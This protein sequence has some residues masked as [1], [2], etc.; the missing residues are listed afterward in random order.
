MPLKLSPPLLSVTPIFYIFVVYYINRHHKFPKNTSC[1][2]F[3]CTYSY[4]DV[5]M[6]AYNRSRWSVIYFAVYISVTLYFLMNLVR[7]NSISF[8]SLTVWETKV[9]FLWQHLRFFCL[10]LLDCAVSKAESCMHV[11]VIPFFL[12]PKSAF[13]A[14]YYVIS[15]QLYNN[16]KAHSS[17]IAE[18]CFQL[19][20]FL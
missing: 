20:N 8:L 6:P 17:C 11:H 10:F 12:N 7:K 5:M 13:Y 14:K 2:Y 4:P 9:I 1:K 19:F 18:N 3:L 16:N 15:W